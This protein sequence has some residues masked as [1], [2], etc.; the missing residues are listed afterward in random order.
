MSNEAVKYVLGLQIPDPNAKRVFMVLAGLTAPSAMNSPI[1]GLELK[2]ADIPALAERAGLSADDF[3]NLLRK[4]KTLV[5]MDVLEHGDSWEIVY[6]PSHTDREATNQP[7]A[8]PLAPVRSAAPKGPPASSITHPRYWLVHTLPWPQG[9]ASVRECA[10]AHA[11][12]L[13]P[14][15]LLG[16]DATSV[17]LVADA[18]QQQT[19]LRTVFFSDLTRWLGQQGRT[20]ADVNRADWENG[21]TQ[22][23]QTPTLAL[24][25]GLS[26]FH[27]TLVGDPSLEQ[28]VLYQPGQ[29]PYEVTDEDRRQVRDFVDGVLAR[30][31]PGYAQSM[32]NA[33]KIRNG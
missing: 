4:L 12:S 25:L 28:L 30:D 7:Q 1:M 19:G 27:H 15:Q 21:L 20:W 14:R 10:L 29:Q 24:Y 11:P 8:A 17:L 13:I 2:D 3:R 23:Q 16:A 33:G 26:Q 6:G 32:I 9:T 5:R 31:W 18:Y 22:L